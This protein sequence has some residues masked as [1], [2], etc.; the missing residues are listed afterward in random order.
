MHDRIAVELTSRS[1]TDNVQIVYSV[2]MTSGPHLRIGELS[3]RTGVSTE[4]PG[5]HHDLGLAPRARGGR[6]VSLGPDTPTAGD[7]VP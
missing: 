1:R 4:L 6:I 5:E 3:K 2:V 7:V